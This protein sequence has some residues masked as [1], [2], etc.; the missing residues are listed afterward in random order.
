[1][2]WVYSYWSEVWN[3]Y[4]T[5]NKSEILLS[6]WNIHFYD[7]I[8]P[9]FYTSDLTVAGL[10]YLSERKEYFSTSELS[11]AILDVTVKF[12]NAEFILL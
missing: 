3:L 4:F 7:F 9:L 8:C 6:H 5:L 10:W 11:S 12:L 1:M 2:L